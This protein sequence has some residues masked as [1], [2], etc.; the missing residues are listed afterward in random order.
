MVRTKENSGWRPVQLPKDLVD[1]V[2]KIIKKDVIKKQGITSISQFISRT[3]NN[4]LEKLEETGFKATTIKNDVIQIFDENLGDNGTLVSIK[5]NKNKLTCTI[6]NSQDCSHVNY[7]WSLEAVA[8]DL[9]E[10]GLIRTEKT[11]PKCGV[12]AKQIEIENIF[13]YRKNNDKKITQSWCKDCRI[14]SKK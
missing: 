12:I 13:G 7:I 6:C 10:S 11:C 14:A 2:E 8:V 5:Q 4:A 3:T 9:E 1:Q